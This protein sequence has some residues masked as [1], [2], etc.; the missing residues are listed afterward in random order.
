MSDP[1]TLV[2]D[3]GGNNVKL[4]HSHK[5]ERR[6]LPSGGDFSPDALVAL[7]RGTMK[8]WPCERVTIGTPGAV[9]NDR[10]V[11]APV[12]LGPGWEGFDFEAAIGMPTRTINDALLQAIGSYEGGKMLFLGLG[13]GLGAALVVEDV[14]LSLEVAHLPYS[15]GKTFE[16]HVGRRGLDKLGRERWESAVHDVCRRL[17][18]ALVAEYIILGGG[19]TKKL[20]ALP[21]LARAGSNDNARIGGLRVWSDAV[22]TW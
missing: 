7:I 22:R 12:N 3:V 14:A 19:N 9:R 13:T 17:R 6:K 11:S 16:D 15:N 21:E 18:E 4:Y 1:P 20:Q 8:D 5:C 2:V 10:I